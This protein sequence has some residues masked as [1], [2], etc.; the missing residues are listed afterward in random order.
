LVAADLADSY[1]SAHARLAVDFRTAA[2]RRFTLLAEGNLPRLPE[3]SQHAA[4]RLYLDTLARLCEGL[5]KTVTAY[6][7]ASDGRRKR[8]HE[9]WMT[10]VP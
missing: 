9:A 2:C 1:E 4:D 10:S 6:E 5:E 3:R 8:I 7:G